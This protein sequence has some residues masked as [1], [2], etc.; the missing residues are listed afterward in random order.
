LSSSSLNHIV[1]KISLF[2]A[3]EQTELKEILDVLEKDYLSKFTLGKFE[4]RAFRLPDEERST[5]FPRSQLEA[6]I[7]STDW[8]AQ[9]L[10]VK[11]YIEHSNLSSSCLCSDDK[12]VVQTERTIEKLQE[13][14]PE[15]SKAG[16][17]AEMLKELVDFV[18]EEVDQIRVSVEQVRNAVRS[19]KNLKAP[20]L[21]LLRYEHLKQLIGRGIKPAPAMKLNSVTWCRK[22]SKLFWQEKC[23][24]RLF[25]P[26]M[27][28]SCVGFQNQVKMRL[29]IAIAKPFCSTTEQ[30]GRLSSR[31]NKSYVTGD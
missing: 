31:T 29:L 4:K 17:T 24:H 3:T 8:S 20:G 19:G 6:K 13:K 25:S 12:F 16:L 5:L 11:R 1:S 27:T 2:T 7:H 28:M 26:S 14:H 23:L 10:K 9:Q 15:A 30:A 22:S 21:D 18:I